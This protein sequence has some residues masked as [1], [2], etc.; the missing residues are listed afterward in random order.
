MR[1]PYSH[2]LREIFSFLV[3]K[4]WHMYAYSHPNMDMGWKWTHNLLKSAGN[5]IK[6]A[7]LKLYFKDECHLDANFLIYILTVYRDWFLFQLLSRGIGM[8]IAIL[9]GIQSGC[10]IQRN[11]S[12]IFLEKILH[13]VCF[14]RERSLVCKL[15][16][17]YF[18]YLL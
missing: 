15:L 18:D 14:S 7:L 1:L 3:G 12:Y 5:L 11:N 16:V 6:N 4:P 8:R 17:L 9:T 10:K 2:S 13:D